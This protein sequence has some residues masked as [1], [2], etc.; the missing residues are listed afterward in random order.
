MNGSKNIVGLILS[1]SLV[2]AQYELDSVHVDTIPI[3][4]AEKKITF[5]KTDFFIGI[6]LVGVSMAAASSMNVKAENHY[7]D[8][9]REGNIDLIN[10]HYNKARQ[11]DRY[12]STVYTGVQVGIW[13][14]IKAFYP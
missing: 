5:N 13:F 10:G 11:Y 9:L 4:P 1:I 6:T 3:I 7:R 12:A 14:I 2:A 8:Y